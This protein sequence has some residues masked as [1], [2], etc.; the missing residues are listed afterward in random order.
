M[1]YPDSQGEKISHL[2]LNH[3]FRILHIE[4]SEKETINYFTP[5]INFS[6]HFE[7]IKRMMAATPDMMT[8]RIKKS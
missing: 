3:L 2:F 1:A 6:N 8:N 4:M 5:P 7:R